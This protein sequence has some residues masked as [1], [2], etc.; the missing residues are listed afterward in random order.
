MA[1]QAKGRLIWLGVCLFPL[2]VHAG[3]APIEPERDKLL[4]LSDGKSHYVAVRPFESVEHSMFYGDGKRFF[5]VPLQGRGAQGT[6]AFSMRF[7]DPRHYRDYQNNTDLIFQEGKYTLSCGSHNT[8]LTPVEPAAAKAL[9]DKARFEPS[10][11]K[12][13]PYALARD[14]N[15]I[16]YYVDQGRTP[17]TAKHFRLFIG[18]KGDLKLQKMTNVVSDSEGDIFATKTGSMRLILDKKETAW[19]A[20]GKTT[21]LRVVPVDDNVAMI[22]NELGVYS[23]E[24]LGTPCDDL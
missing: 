9:L 10:P 2:S 15:G 16:Y 3:D 14:P 22:F 20:A 23:G 21:P 13:R 12:F 18:P 19:T 5:S 17:E 7:V 6:H 24:R 8:T 11:R 1:N 4:L